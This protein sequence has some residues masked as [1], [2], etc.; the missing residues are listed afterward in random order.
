MRD[1]AELEF[2]RQATVKDLTARFD[3]RHRLSIGSPYQAFWA[4][5]RP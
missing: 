5:E 4:E 3:I 1:T 2:A